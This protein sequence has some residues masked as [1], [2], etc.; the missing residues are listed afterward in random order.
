MAGSLWSYS[1]KRELHSSSSGLTGKYQVYIFQNRT[2]PSCHFYSKTREIIDH[3]ISACSMSALVE[4]P[5]TTRIDMVPTQAHMPSTHIWEDL[6][7]L[8]KQQKIKPASFWD[9]NIQND[10]L[11]REIDQ[12]LWLKVMWTKH[13]CWW[14]CRFQQ[15]ATHLLKIFKKLSKYNRDL[16]T[17]ASESNH[18]TI[19]H[20]S[21][22]FDSR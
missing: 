9:F 2:E 22:G 3:L 16:K 10:G 1:R 20:W 6:M 4:S 15:T 13:I 14:A 17:T 19:N 21:L 7:S 12:M 11:Y 8:P 18:H 5:L